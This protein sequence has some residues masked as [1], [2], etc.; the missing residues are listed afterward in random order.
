MSGI[1]NYPSG[2]GTGANYLQTQFTK[3]LVNTT[4]TS[5]TF[6][7]LITVLVTI[8]AGSSLQISFAET[9]SSSSASATTFFRV[10]VDAIVMQGAATR[11]PGGGDPQGVSINDYITGL[12]AGV[13]TVKVQWRTNS[14]TSRIRPV[15]SPDA[16]SASILI[17]EVSN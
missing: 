8:Q 3:L 17:N 10:T 14:G 4:T 2:P 6:V 5:S 12:A 9:N 15:A 1:A 7:D 13:H 11:S 16:E